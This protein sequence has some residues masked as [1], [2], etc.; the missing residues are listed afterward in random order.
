MVVAYNGL[1][2]GEAPADDILAAMQQISEFVVSTF[3]SEWPRINMFYGEMN[4]VIQDSL[5]AYA[6]Y[7]IGTI[8]N[9][10]SPVNCMY[11]TVEWMNPT[12]VGECNWKDYPYDA[13]SLMMFSQLIPR[14]F[15]CK[16]TQAD[17]ETICEMRHGG[18]EFMH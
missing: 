18:V 5:V 3:D 10:T 13:L 1:E 9:S 2:V 17:G 15:V 11:K 8:Y 16:I 4:E 12:L 6:N 14:G 7:P